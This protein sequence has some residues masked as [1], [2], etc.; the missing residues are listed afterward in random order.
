MMMP[1]TCIYILLVAVMMRIKE[2]MRSITV[3]DKAVL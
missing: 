3:L 1:I 2:M